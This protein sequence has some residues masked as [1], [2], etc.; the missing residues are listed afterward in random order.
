MWIDNFWTPNFW[1]TNFWTGEVVIEDLPDIV[2]IDGTTNFAITTDTSTV[3]PS[4]MVGGR[5]TC[6]VQDS[7]GGIIRLGHN[8]PYVSG[9]TAVVGYESPDGEWGELPVK[10]FDADYVK[11]YIPE[12]LLDTE[13][14]YWKF[15]IKVT[16]TR[17]GQPF[18]IISSP[19]EIKVV[20]GLVNEL[21]Y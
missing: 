14:K 13:D 9:Y 19:L 4:G 17:N 20:D 8:F 2:L 15:N 10:S 3:L 12:G 7:Y 11:A 16:G 6:P 5:F 1:T 21:A 18:K